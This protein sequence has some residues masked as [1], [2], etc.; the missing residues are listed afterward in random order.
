[1]RD[2][3]GGYW[4]WLSVG[5]RAAPILATLSLLTGVLEGL[6][7][8][9]QAFGISL[10]INGLIAHNR[11]DMVTGVALLLVPYAVNFILMVVN[12]PIIDTLFF[13]ANSYV[14]GDL[15][16]IVAGIP[17]IEHHENPDVADRIEL[18]HRDIHRM[19][20]AVGQLLFFVTVTV[21]VITIVSL[22]VTVSPWLVLLLMAG[23]ARVITGFIDSRLKWNAI[24]AT[25]QENRLA[26]TLQDQVKASANGVE[27]RVFGLRAMLIRRLDEGYGNI[28]STRGVAIR[29]GARFEVLSRLLFGA[30]YVAAIAFVAVQARHGHL[31]PG[32]IAM[33]VLL[34]SRIEQTAGGIAN[35]TRNIGE[36]V[37]VFG[38]YAWLRRYAAQRTWE[39]AKLHAPARLT[40]GIELR[41]V[42]FRYP[43]AER[44]VLTDLNL[45]LPA[46]CTVALVGE[47]GAG[48][49]TLVK[50]LGRLYDPTEGAVLVD[51]TD[52]RDISPDKWRERTSAAFQD[53]VK[54]EF[55]AGCTVG[56]GDLGHLDDEPAV[57]AAV[58]RG[59]ATELVGRMRDGLQ[60]QLGKRFSDGVELS[61]GQWQRL[62]L[63]RGF[64]RTRPLLLL[65][66]E[67]TAALDPEAEHRLY[68]QFAAAS[69]MAAAETGGV[70][71]LVSHRFST[72]R[73]ADLI[74][75]MDAGRIIEVDTHDDL[76]RSNHRY[77]E[78]FE[79]Q[80]RAY[81]R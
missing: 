48:K 51:G 69:R 18:L 16:R 50:L 13:K 26:N 27:M 54:F 81:R 39:E 40:H 33:V 24:K 77:A 46:G 59:D 71:V 10:T 53:F 29:K 74:V 70:T 44:G 15:M 7:A 62:A 3:L 49:S 36:T 67:P 42:G 43:S 34:G 68:D 60:T 23:V 72:V 78:L 20:F 65:L 73:M 75:V 19:S 9:L 28:E 79:L 22:L 8:P 35:L 55:T 2:R 38:L 45:F 61:G 6:A 37:R 12:A 31:K 80:A 4:L 21:N 5:F 30:A 47:N 1:M 58:D 14:H 56:I 52:L 66:D 25:M 11:N 57:R 63:A 41:G 64:M 32:S 76:L 17:G